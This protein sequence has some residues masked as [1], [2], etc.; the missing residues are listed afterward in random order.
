[1]PNYYLN[2]EADTKGNYCLHVESCP[3]LHPSKVFTLVGNFDKLEE[4][5]GVIKSS[6]YSVTLCKDCIDINYAK[7]NLT[8]KEPL[9]NRLQKMIKK[10]WS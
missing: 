1:M 3:N 9:L 10:L 5:I 4:V 7:S 6:D 8:T 2:T